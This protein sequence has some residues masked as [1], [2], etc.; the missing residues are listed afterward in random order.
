[1]ERRCQ[2]QQSNH[3]VEEGK[4]ADQ[5]YLDDW[6]KRCSRV[7]VLKHIGAGVAPWNNVQYE[8]TNRTGGMPPLIND[9]PLIFYHFHALEFFCPI[10]MIV[11]RHSS[12]LFSESVLNC[13]C[14]PY[15]LAI[16]DVVLQVGKILPGFSE[17]LNKDNLVQPW[18]TLIA[19]KTSSEIIMNAGINHRIMPL[20]ET[21]DCYCSDQI[22]TKIC[23][24]DQ[25]AQ[26]AASNKLFERIACI[27]ATKDI[28]LL[29]S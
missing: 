14:Y 19:H 5:R 24:D 16:H 13:C 11:S 29:Q 4:Y 23:L 9:V 8:I 27:Q 2:T 7:H 12:Y 21:W 28:I 26:N 18:M 10:L 25:S 1:M 22:I 6:P 15:L 3:D 17:G 20:D